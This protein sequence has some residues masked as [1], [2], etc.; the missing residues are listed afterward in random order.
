MEPHEPCTLCVV[1]PSTLFYVNDPIF[2]PSSIHSL[3][4]S[5]ATP[6]LCHSIGPYDHKI[7]SMSYVKYLNE[8]LLA[9]PVDKGM[10]T[11]QLDTGVVKWGRK[12]IQLPGPNKNCEPYCLA[13]DRK[14]RLFVTDLSNKCI[15]MFSVSDGQYLGCFIKEGEQSLGVLGKYVSVHQR[16]NLL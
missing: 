12:D 13:A 5:G 7:Y 3:D 8:N 1:P 16:H 14:G 15:Q 2:I 6:T 9:I 11:F 4:C 10:Q